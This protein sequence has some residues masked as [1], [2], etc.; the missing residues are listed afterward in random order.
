MPHHLL[1]PISPFRSL[2]PSLAR[3]LAPIRYF[4]R[5]LAPIGPLVLSAHYHEYDYYYHF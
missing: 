2:A 5:S 4:A 3:S 1:V